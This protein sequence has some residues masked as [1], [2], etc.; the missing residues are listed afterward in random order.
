MP[1]ILTYSEAK[2]VVISGDIHGEFDTLVY[3]MCVQYDMHD[4]LLI[5]AGDCGFGFEKPAYY[6][7]VFQ[8][9]QKRLTEHNCWV[10]MIRGNHDN[11]V[12]FEQQMIAHERFRTMPDYMVVE[13]CGHHILCVGGAISIDRAWRKQQMMRQPGKECYWRD[14]MPRYDA[15]MLNDIKAAGIPIDIVV[16]HTAPSF[17]EL[18]TKSGLMSWASQDPDL[19]QDCDHER[20]QMDELLKHLKSDGHPVARWCYGHFHQSWHS[21][22]LGTFFKMLDIREFYEL[23]QGV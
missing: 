14:E 21:E 7:Q 4:T 9:V 13:A 18:Q 22:I 23:P 12:Y 3:Q 15:A 5:V 20:E 11:S 6:E 8:R 1:N 16:T 19:L 17:C 2:S 10:A